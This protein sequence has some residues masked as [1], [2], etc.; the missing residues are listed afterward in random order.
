MSRL[1]EIQEFNLMLGETIMYCQTIE[2]DLKLLY[3][4]L[5]NDRLEKTM[6]RIDNWALGKT[7]N[8]L[9]QLDNSYNKPYL[10]KEDYKLLRGIAEDRN[11]LCHEIY[12]T[13]LYITNWYFSDEYQNA[14]NKLISV[15][16]DLDKIS[17][18]IQQVRL[19]ASKIYNK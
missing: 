4:I 9:Q 10:S 7:I 3:A 14:C 17:D 15:H 6:N 19:N 5:C 2:H 11:Y 1:L 16:D 12:R 8:E 13:F 18:I